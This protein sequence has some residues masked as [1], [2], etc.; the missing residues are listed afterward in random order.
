M[1]KAALLVVLIGCA[2]PTPSSV[3][4]GAT[5]R[6]LEALGGLMKNDV[7][8]A[9]SKVVFLLA[10]ADEGTE[11][12]RAVRS[13]LE[14]ATVNLRTAIG[15]LRLW[16]NPPTESAEGRDVFLTYAASIDDMAGKLVDAL[17]REDRTTA[18]KHLEQI[19]DTCNNCHHFFRLKIDDSVVMR[20]VERSKRSMQ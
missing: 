5:I 8:P 2:K 19:A 12:P 10:H 15:K 20:S 6:K 4:D 3:N 14:I 11:D 16:H 18:L 17:D 1:N 9:F 7:N 13:E